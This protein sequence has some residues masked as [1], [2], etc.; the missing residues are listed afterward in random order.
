[1]KKQPMK[2]PPQMK[3]RIWK[4][5]VE[6]MQVMKEGMLTGEQSAQKRGVQ[7]I[8]KTEK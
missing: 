2:K 6:W 1:M 4:Q 8:S 3:K 5:H 7:P